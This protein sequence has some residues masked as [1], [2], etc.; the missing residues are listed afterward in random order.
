MALFTSRKSSNTVN[1]VVT[2][3]SSFNKS[4]RARET[5]RNSE[6]KNATQTS[7]SNN[8][9][10]S[11]KYQWLEDQPDCPEFNNV[12]MNVSSYEAWIVEYGMYSM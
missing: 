10:D 5:G 8:E 6:R 1:I 2:S 9:D 4:E 12:Y 11:V 7:H 3:T